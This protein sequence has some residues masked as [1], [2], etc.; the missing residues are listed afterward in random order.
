MA[1]ELDALRR[2][3]QRR[4]R[5]EREWEQE[6]RRLFIAGHSIDRIAAAAGVRYE[7]V[8]E[9][10]NSLGPAYPGLTVPPLSQVLL[11]HALPERPTMKSVM[12]PYVPHF[13]FAP[14]W[15]TLFLKT[16]F[17]ALLESPL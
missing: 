13:P 8:I 15:K 3:T 9:I 10:D 14:R 16:M 6:I 5:A 7:A 4:A 1:D 11:D 2:I 12:G 17:V